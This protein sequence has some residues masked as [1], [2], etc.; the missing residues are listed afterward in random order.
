MF[1]YSLLFKKYLLTQSMLLKVIF[2]VCNLAALLFSA[3]LS[4]FIR[5]DSR[6]KLLYLINI[7]I[8][9]KYLSFHHQ[10]SYDSIG[11]FVAIVW[12]FAFVF[13]G[14]L[15]YVTINGGSRIYFI[16]INSAIFTLGALALFSY[17]TRISYSRV[18]FIVIVPIGLL[19]Q[20]FTNFILRKII[21]VFRRKFNILSKK[22]IIIGFE[23]DVRRFEKLM[24]R[25]SAFGYRVNQEILV[26]SQNISS[27]KVKKQL[28]G[29]TNSSDCEAVMIVGDISYY[30]DFVREV[31]WYIEGKGLEFVLDSKL[32]TIAGSRIRVSAMH[33]IP[34]IHIDVWQGFGV[35]YFFKRFFDIVFA[36]CI[37]LLS[38]PILLVVALLIKVQDGGPI[39]Y[40]QQR[41]GRYGKP[42]NIIKFR[43]MKVGAD[44]ELEEVLA[45]EGK[46]V[47]ALY[48]IEDDP[49]VT[50]IGKFIRKTSLDEFPQ[51]LNVI[52][53]SM[54]VVGPR[55]QIVEEIN[56]N[57]AV[58]NRRLKVKPGVT[59]AWQVSG[60]SSLS[61]EESIEIDINYVENW[62]IF[63]DVIIV[64]QTIREL[65]MPKGA[66]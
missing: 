1:D 19:F 58:Y 3:Y 20:F 66:Y 31:R 39:F 2:L 17:F 38:G 51:F 30:G 60:R 16:C 44:K 46:K 54:S 18:L 45:K 6:N 52:A 43:S 13:Q 62:T 28:E 47:E 10:M 21:R 53:G 50:K 29:Y 32:T 40:L 12:L 26:D 34:L 4:L 63:T 23:K 25:S 56:T 36:V 15:R 22:T 37:L 14:G 35:K 48:K 55:P 59:G 9:S 65:I 24:S 61:L 27:R 7:D 33:N 49:R 5:F 57:G 8:N 42:F 11:H 41:I 64:I